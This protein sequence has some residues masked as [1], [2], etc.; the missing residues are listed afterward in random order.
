MAL[1]VHK[2]AEIRELI[3][4][5]FLWEGSVSLPD[6]PGKSSVLH[7]CGPGLL[8]SC[9]ND[10]L[11]WCTRIPSQSARVARRDQTVSTKNS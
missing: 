5:I 2:A 3:A 7:A 10:S 8:T 9:A 1:Y 6:C 11:R 4:R